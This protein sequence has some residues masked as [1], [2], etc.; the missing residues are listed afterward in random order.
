MSVSVDLV[1]QGSIVELHLND[2]TRRNA[3]SV[4]LGDA[5]RAR[6]QEI[7]AGALP[8]AVII[9][10]ANGA[11]SAGGDLAMLEA[12]TTMSRDASR[13]AMRA[14][15]ARFLSLLDLPMPVLAAVDGPA[16]GAGLCVAAACD[17]VLVGDESKLAF[18]FVKLGLHPGMAATYFLPRR[19]GA[20]RAAELLFTGRTFDGKEAVAMGL[21]MASAPRGEVLPLARKVAA[22]IAASAPLA[23]TSLKQ[24]LA[25]DRAELE[26]ALA[27]ESEAQAGSYATRD[28]LE[29][30]AAI[31]GKRAGAFSGQ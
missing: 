2:A 25:V 5:F 1:R 6:V 30:I 16:I 31:K 9:T 18:N 19:V 17:L 10:G 15:Y 4:A 3:M 28:F 20:Q 21:A 8:R 14:F 12:F 7:L 11:F 26:R 24:S 13:D 29:G 22:D 27:R 23:V